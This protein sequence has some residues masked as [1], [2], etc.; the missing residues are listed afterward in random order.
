MLNPRE[1]F[2]YGWCSHFAADFVSTD[3][4]IKKVWVPNVKF[5]GQKSTQFTY[6]SRYGEKFSA[7]KTIKDDLNYYSHG[8]LNEKDYMGLRKS[9]ANL[10]TANFDNAVKWMV[11]NTSLNHDVYTAFKGIKI[12]GFR[13]GC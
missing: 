12:F 1:V 3:L 7:T 9:L 5:N 6:L 2:E 8:I 4:F 11:R 10:T 13:I